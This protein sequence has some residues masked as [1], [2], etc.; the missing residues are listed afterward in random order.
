MKETAKLH[1]IITMGETLEILIPF[2]CTTTFVRYLKVNIE[3]F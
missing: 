3:R 1:K 2:C